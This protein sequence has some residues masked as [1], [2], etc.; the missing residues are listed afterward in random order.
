[1]E[2]KRG[3]LIDTEWRFINAAKTCSEGPY[4][5]YTLGID[6]AYAV[7]MGAPTLNQLRAAKML[8]KQ[9]RSLSAKAGVRGENAFLL[10]WRSNPVPNLE[11]FEAFAATDWG[12][13]IMKSDRFDLSLDDSPYA[14]AQCADRGHLENDTRKQM[15]LALE[16]GFS[17]GEVS[18]SVLETL[19][20]WLSDQCDSDEDVKQ[21]IRDSHI[22]FLA[23]LEHPVE[24]GQIKPR[25]LA[26]RFWSLCVEQARR[27][28]AD[29]RN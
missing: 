23:R 14:Q 16:R 25:A 13:A 6:I 5:C 10:A 22:A 11:N 12:R 9:A 28:L 29:F 1:M 18:L 2:R 3:E 8:A 7:R 19:E 4:L 17:R 20:Y 21:F 24:L 26:G 27:H 15:S